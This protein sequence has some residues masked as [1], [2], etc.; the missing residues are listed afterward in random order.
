MKQII[1][2]SLLTFSIVSS[3]GQD[4]KS[5]IQNFFNADNFTRDTLYIKSRFMECGE[6]GGHLELSKVYLNGNDFYINYQKFD[7][8]CN[9]VNDNNLTPNQKLVKDIT[10]KLLDKDKVLIRLYMH[11]LLD[12]KF[13]EPIPMNA[14]YIFEVTKSDNSILI[15]VYTWGVTTKNQYLKFIKTLL[16]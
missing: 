8:D 6:W 1:G 13:R 5:D 2:L 7:A 14:G 4:K 3:S 16:E 9:S 10:K 12:A 11:Q 15:N